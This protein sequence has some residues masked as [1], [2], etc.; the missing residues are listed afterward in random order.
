MLHS[1][2]VLSITCVVHVAGAV[3]IRLLHACAYAGP[4]SHYM[5][6]R[7]TESIQNIAT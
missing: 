7:E 2:G 5:Y 3:H 1:M 6:G 4:L